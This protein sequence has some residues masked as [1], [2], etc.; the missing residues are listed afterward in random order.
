M[1]DSQDIADSF[2]CADFWSLPNWLNGS[3]C[4]LQMALGIA[5]TMVSLLLFMLSLPKEPIWIVPGFIVGFSAVFLAIVTHELGHFLAARCC[6]I[7]V[8]RVRVGRWDVRIL[9]KG[10][11]VSRRPKIEPRLGGFVLAFMDPRGPWRRQQL[12][13]VAGGPLANLTL[14]GVA[15]LGALLVGHG[16]TQGALLALAAANVC[17]GVANLL[18]TQRKAV[19]SDGL[20]LLR[21]W[22]G[23]DINHP[24]LAFMRL[25]GLACA[26]T[27]SDELPEKD[28]RLLEAQEQPMPLLAL[29]IR[30]RALLVQGRW[31][32]A[33]D[34]GVAFQV[35]RSSLPETLQRALYELL[36]LMMVELSFAEA[37][38]RRDASGLVDDL[39]VPRLRREYAG[40]WARCLALRALL[41]GD[42]EELRRQLTLGL[43]HAANSPDLSL[44]KEESQIQQCMLQSFR[45]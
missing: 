15:G 21:W 33:M 11:K 26:G 32:D 23:L 24:Q 20:W 43:E 31:Q 4:L 28:L 12:W 45:G 9:R 3:L 17:L 2:R 18:P 13:F 7:A 14:A 44:E 40:I 19:T 16:A 35:H 10:W 39:L 25:M 22:R 8:L 30:L 27:C 29:Y 6:N 41:A 42:E 37:M 1:S 36:R 5:A 38:V 34:L